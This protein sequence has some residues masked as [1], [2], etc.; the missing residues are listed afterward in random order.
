MGYIRRDL[1]GPALAK[2][3]YSLKFK[4]TILKH[5]PTTT[6]NGVKVFDRLYTYINRVGVQKS[7]SHLKLYKLLGIKVKD[8]ESGDY[9]GIENTYLSVPG[10]DL[11]YDIL[12]SQIKSYIDLNSPII[13]PLHDDVF[14][15]VDRTQYITTGVP[16]QVAVPGSD[17]V[18]YTTVYDPY[19]KTDLN[20]DEFKDNPEWVYADTDGDGDF[21][22]VDTTV[23][24][25][26]WDK[27]GWITTYLT[28]N[29]PTAADVPETIGD[30]AI[31]GL[32]ESGDRTS[33]HFDDEEDHPLTFASLLDVD[34]VMFENKVRIVQKSIEERITT[35]YTL[36]DRN[37][38][39]DGIQTSRYMKTAVIEYKFRRIRD[40]DDS[41]VAT[42]IA[43]IESEMEALSLKLIQ[44]INPI[45]RHLIL[46]AYTFGASLNSSVS[47][48]LIRM[49]HS[50]V[51]SAETIL[52]YNRYLKYAAIATLKAKD[53]GKTFS[54]QITQGHTL[55]KVKWYKKVLVIVIDIIVIIVAVVLIM[56]GNFSAAALVLSFGAMLQSALAYYWAKNGDPAA[57]NYAMGHA[58][59][60]GTLAML[61]GI[62]GLLS[63]GYD[64][65]VGEAADEL[66][67]EAILEAIKEYGQ[68]AITDAIIQASVVAVKDVTLQQVVDYVIHNIIDLVIKAVQAVVLGGM[69]NYATMT[70]TQLLMAGLQIL[71]Q[72][73]SI[74]TQYIDPSQDDIA[75][76][77]A[78]LEASNK[79][80]EDTAGPETLDTI[81]VEYSDPFTN[82]IDMNEKMQSTPYMMTVGKNKLLMNKYYNSGY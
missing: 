57:A 75:D 23:P 4:N 48:Q 22:A 14:N 1:T 19:I 61:V 78:E 41:L 64:Y 44:N 52:S 26:Q 82:W 20:P 60:L 9:K 70:T 18:T 6:I 37:L 45:V 3:Q 28:Y 46:Q 16:R 30:A 17:P 56:S 65:I 43:K 31:L 12:P 35:T 50:E 32:I 34:N 81:E 40:V 69:N 55:K 79:E 54:K 59:F 39:A 8:L 76:K 80:L 68:E 36:T 67:Q 10:I 77:K 53:F 27:D 15:P 63:G 38:R 11:T 71:N 49:Y 21:E 2:F 58:E 73:F 51:G 42:L 33:I 7:P 24:E 47:K 66:T 29:P 25:P 13:H 5:W 72:G 62:A 74:Y